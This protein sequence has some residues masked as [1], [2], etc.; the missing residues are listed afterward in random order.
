MIGEMFASFMCGL[1]ILL[2]LEIL[3]RRKKHKEQEFESSVEEMR[4]RAYQM[5]MYQSDID[6][7]E[8]KMRDK[9]RRDQGN[10]HPIESVLE[11]GSK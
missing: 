8:N 10:P 1:I 9:R 7:L 2:A 5:G 4:V 6:D 11:G 3:E